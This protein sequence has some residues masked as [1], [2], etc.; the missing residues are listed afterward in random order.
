MKKQ[1]TKASDKCKTK[2]KNHSRFFPFVFVIF[3]ENA[4]KPFFARK[5]SP[6][7]FHNPHKKGADRLVDS[8]FLARY[9]PNAFEIIA[10]TKETRIRFRKGN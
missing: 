7:L 4:R 5:R 8:C 3:G 10:D 6:P 1:P 9:K 2:G